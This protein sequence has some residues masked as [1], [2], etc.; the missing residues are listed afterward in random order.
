MPDE[1]DCI[2]VFAGRPERKPYAIKLFQEGLSQRLIISIGRFEWR[3]FLK[4]GLQ[5]Y[6]G[7]LELVNQTPARQRHFFLHI[8][9]SMTYAK[10]IT[11]KHF[12]TL[13]EAVALA[14]FIEHQHVKR[15]MLISNGFHL[16]RATKAVRSFCRDQDVEI[17]PVAVPDELAGGIRH[18]WWR[19]RKIAALL[20]GEYFKILL[21]TFLL[22]PLYRLPCMN[23]A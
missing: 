7:L 16:R 1:V 3:G 8:A 22:I 14:G 17:V 11:K 9:S 5:D 20:V 13:T 15:L 21:Y 19:N 6:G 2:F 23:H 12:G 4:L 18:T 10:L